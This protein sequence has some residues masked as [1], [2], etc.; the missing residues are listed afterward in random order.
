MI[1]HVDKLTV[2]SDGTGG[3]VKIGDVEIGNIVS[4]VHVD[5]HPGDVPMVTLKICRIAAGPIVDGAANVQI[6]AETADTLIG[7]GWTPP[8]EQPALVIADSDGNL[9]LVCREC[10]SRLH[11]VK[12]EIGLET[13]VLANRQ[14]TCPKEGGR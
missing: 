5:L 11:R 14:H 2:T 12:D 10:F 1:S 7:L 8:A 13:L 6:D 3:T 9:W 4:S